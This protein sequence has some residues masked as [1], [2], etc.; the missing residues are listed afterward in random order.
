MACPGRFCTTRARTVIKTQNCHAWKSKI[1]LLFF[2]TSLR[3]ELAISRISDRGDVTG[4]L[5]LGNPGLSYQKGGM[6]VVWTSPL[7]F[8]PRI[9]YSFPKAARK[10]YQKLSSLS[11]Q[12]LKSLMVQK[13]EVQTQGVS[14]DT[15]LPKALGENPSLPI[16]APG[17]SR[18]PLAR[19]SITPNFRLLSSRGLTLSLCPPL[20]LDLGPALSKYHL[21]LIVTSE[22]YLQ[23]P[24]KVKFYGCE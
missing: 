17:G 18:H 8:Q 16:P 15:F 24:R 11:Q 1:P 21:I 10:N 5:L 4:R 9:V 19:G 14:R 13:P 12:K 23:R 20:S 3:P 7:F 6:L 22:L 2:S